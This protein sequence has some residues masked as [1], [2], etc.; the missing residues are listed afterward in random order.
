MICVR[1]LVYQDYAATSTGVGNQQMSDFHKQT[2]CV[3]IWSVFEFLN[4]D[5]IAPREKGGSLF[6]PVILSLKREDDSFDMAMKTGFMNAVKEIQQFDVF[7]PYEWHQ[8]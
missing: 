5:Q 6:Q 8:K 4:L 1:L 7:C 3:F 2:Q